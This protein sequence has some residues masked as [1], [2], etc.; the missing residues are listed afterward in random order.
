MPD[1]NERK[2]ETHFRLLNNENGTFGVVKDYPNAQKILKQISK[3]PTTFFESKDYVGGNRDKFYLTVTLS[4]G[5]ICNFLVKAKMWNKHFEI[6]FPELPGKGGDSYD[7]SNRRASVEN[8]ILAN[9]EAKKRYLA[10]YGED[11][12]IERPVGFY[13]S[14]KEGH[15]GMRWV[16]FERL[17]V[18]HSMNS[19]FNADILRKKAREYTREIEKKLADI[20]IYTGDN[21]D[22]VWTGDMNDVNSIR[23]VIVDSEEWKITNPPP[24]L[25]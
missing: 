13:L 2:K 24:K 12:P 5:T 16:I 23:F 10:K 21:L 6:F 11:L 17:N 18:V 9:L 25:K 20:G 4:D 19:A 3:D 7:Q 14:R 22:I 1:T 15:R 8:E